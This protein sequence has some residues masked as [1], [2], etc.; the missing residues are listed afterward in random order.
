MEILSKN[1]NVSSDNTNLFLHHVS[2]AAPSF[3]LG[4]INDGGGGI[5]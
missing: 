3:M 5:S 4:A 1:G 2:H